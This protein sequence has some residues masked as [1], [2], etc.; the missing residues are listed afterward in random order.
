MSYLDAFLPFEDAKK[1]IK[2]SFVPVVADPL[3]IM[4]TSF[5]E[6]K[7]AGF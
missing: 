6:V 1:C 4:Q 3:A 7:Y 5:E 2:L